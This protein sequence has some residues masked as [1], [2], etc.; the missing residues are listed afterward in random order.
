MSRWVLVAVVLTVYWLRDIR[1]VIRPLTGQ[2]CLPD[3]EVG[4]GVM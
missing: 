3:D 2:S 4:V 1:L